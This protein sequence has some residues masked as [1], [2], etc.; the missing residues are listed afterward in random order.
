MILPNDHDSSM[1]AL[2][3]GVP[4]GLDLF[5]AGRAANAARREASGDRGV[6]T[7]SRRLT[8]S[9]A[10][11]GPKDAAEAYVE[12]ADLPALGGL[13]AALAAGARMVV[14]SGLATAKQAAQLGL[15]VWLRV[16]FAAA[17]SAHARLDRLAAISHAV[18][19]GLTLEGLLPTPVNEAMGLDTL[20]FF[21]L[22]RQQLPHLALA[23]DFARLG[24]R[25]AQ[26]ALGFGANELHG[27]IVSER[28]L[29]LG[30]NANNPAMTRKEAAVFIRGAG[31][32]PHER[33]AAG[34]IEEVMT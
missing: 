2:A 7:R 9:G 14:A 27:P 34:R 26:M 3:E 30:D 24:H 23:A 16:T 25:L 20:A 1:P 5:A 17:E 19:E 21:A 8:A 18:K 32:V 31:L 13:D 28:A 29:R 6:F 22:C 33:L 4:S 10:W 12:E 11:V 15:R